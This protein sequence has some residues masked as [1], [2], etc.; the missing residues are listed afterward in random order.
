MSIAGVKR[1]ELFSG[2][3]PYKNDVLIIKANSRKAQVRAVVEISEAVVSPAT[4]LKKR[5]FHSSLFS[6]E[7]WERMD[8]S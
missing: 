2:N 3:E 4:G 7:S 5:T 6:A 8:H 1:F